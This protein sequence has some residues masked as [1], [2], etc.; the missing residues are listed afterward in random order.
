L[1]AEKQDPAATA[2]LTGDQAAVVELVNQAVTARDS[3]T[4]P[5]PAVNEF[6][7]QFRG[8]LWGY[9]G[10]ALFG[11]VCT[12]PFMPRLATSTPLTS[13]VPAVVAYAAG[14]VWMLGIFALIHWLGMKP[15]P[16]RF[17]RNVLLAA[18][19]AVPVTG[20]VILKVTGA[21]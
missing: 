9:R 8:P 6:E 20:L 12:L 15:W 16:H 3:R 19:L 4:R 13:F 2:R 21:G 7:R 14:F 10:A 5:A 11:A 17:K 1:D 18:F